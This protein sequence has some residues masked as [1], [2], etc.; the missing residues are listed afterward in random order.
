[1]PQHA[2]ANG[3][4]HRELRR[5]QLTTFLSCVVRNMSGS[6]WV[7][8]MGVSLFR[9]LVWHGRASQASRRNGWN[10]TRGHSRAT[11]EP[12]LVG[13]GSR[14]AGGDPATRVGAA[15]ASRR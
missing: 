12:L 9:I 10:L 15:D 8:I 11:P 14:A 1:M 7:S 5:A 13:A 2:V 6:V 3:I 4:G